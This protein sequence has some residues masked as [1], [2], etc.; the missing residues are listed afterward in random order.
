MVVVTLAADVLLFAVWVCPHGLG[1]GIEF[2][3]D[4]VEHQLLVGQADKAPR[5]PN[6]LLL[7]PKVKEGPELEMNG[8][9]TDIYLR[10][11]YF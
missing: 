10:F 4:T 7:L 3:I 8:E 1:A 11:N 9:A 5:E 6:V 2:D